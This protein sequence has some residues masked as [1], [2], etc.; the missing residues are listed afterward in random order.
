[1]FIQPLIYFLFFSFC[2]EKN[3]PYCL[4]LNNALEKNGIYLQFFLV[5]ER[6]CCFQIANTCC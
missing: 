6:F 1:M 2:F 3:L 4:K 5:L